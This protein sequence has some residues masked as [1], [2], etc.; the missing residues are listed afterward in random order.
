MESEVVI[1]SEWFSLSIYDFQKRGI[2]VVNGQ[3]LEK[4]RIRLKSEM[5]RV[6][7]NH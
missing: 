2:R 4:F 1:S 7:E 6:E 3:S 5:K